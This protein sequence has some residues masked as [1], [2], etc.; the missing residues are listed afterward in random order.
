MVITLD[1]V[2]LSVTH[3]EFS[4]RSRAAIGKISGSTVSFSLT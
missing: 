3:A 4:P 1:C 2:A